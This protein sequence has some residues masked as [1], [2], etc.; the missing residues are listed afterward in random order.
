MGSKIEYVNSSQIY[1]AN[2]VRNSK[3]IGVLWGIFTI[4]YA[5]IN[6]VAFIT[7]E[8][9]G[10]A[11][12]SENPTRF[13]LWSTCYINLNSGGIED[14]RGNLHNLLTSDFSPFNVAAIFGIISIFIALLTVVALILFFFCTSTKVYCICGW[15]QFLS[16]KSLNLF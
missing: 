15:M 12:E 14:C 4:C 7:P 3:A 6:S 10:D 2:Y 8:W 9:L 5:I 1:A 13:G 16:G 11:S